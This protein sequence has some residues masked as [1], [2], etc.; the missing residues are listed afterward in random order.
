MCWYPPYLFGFICV[1]THHVYLALYVLV[2]T[3]FIW[4][5]MCWYPPYLFGFI[6]VGNHHI[7]LAL[8]VVV[9]AAAIGGGNVYNKII[10]C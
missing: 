4:L 3:I 10:M 1:G 8:Y 6:C 2:T 9:T 5:N 7:Y